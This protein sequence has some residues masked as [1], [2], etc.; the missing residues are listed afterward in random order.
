MRTA[1][2]A[3]CF[4]LALSTNA[5]AEERAVSRD[6]R[7]EVALGAVGGW[8][9]VAPVDLSGGGFHFE[10]A[11]RMGRLQLQ[12]ELDWLFINGT[13]SDE[14]VPEGTVFR[15]GLAV[16]WFPAALDLLPTMAEE[17]Y[18]E[19]G[20]GRQ[21]VRWDAGGTL[22]RNDLSFGIGVQC[23]VRARA[24]TGSGA[25]RFTVGFRSTVARTADGWNKAPTCGGP[26]DGPSDAAYDVSILYLFA[27]AFGQ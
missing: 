26:C 5:R 24:P 18:L 17:V 21:W 1:V 6:H 8:F 9:D 13:D 14:G 22:A 12:A 3:A 20:L 25:F 4:L 23:A 7:T 11:R 2:A 10:L 15:P 19:G 27:M 16:R